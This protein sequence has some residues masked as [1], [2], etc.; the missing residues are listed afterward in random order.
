MSRVPN[1]QRLSRGAIVGLGQQAKQF[2]LPSFRQ[3]PDVELVAVIE[4]DS[5]VLNSL[6]SAERALLSVDTGTDW[7]ESFDECLKQHSLDFVVIATPHCQ[8]HEAVVTAIENQVNVI[9]EK[10]FAIS[11]G[12]AV[13]IYDL[14]EKEGVVVTTNVQRRFNPVYST[15]F[16]YL[17]RIGQLLHFDIRYNFYAEDYDQGWRA[18]KELAGGGCLIDMGYHM[19]DLL[20]WYFGLPD[21]IRMMTLYSASG[22]AHYTAEDTAYMTFG[23]DSSPLRGTMFVSRSLQ[24]KHE[25]VRIRGTNGYIL[26]QKASVA[27]YSNSGHL[28]ERMC[29]EPTADVGTFSQLTQIVRREIP[30]SCAPWDHLQHTALIEAG[31]L[32]AI[33]G[34]CVDPKEI[35]KN[36]KSK[37]SCLTT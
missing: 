23:Y 35:M 7:F 31:Y 8:H 1:K 30:N 5:R 17:N 21:S 34:N 12:Q 29:G 9:K 19:I 37:P 6:S 33:H 27:R 28:Q 24:P 11:F 18:F 14:Q 4:S 16:E 20:I 25:S 32:S 36:C 10:P 22:N 26:L 15:C 13:Q 2:Y 3:T